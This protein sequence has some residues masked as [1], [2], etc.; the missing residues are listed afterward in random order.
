MT[1]PK[2]KKQSKQ[3]LN[4][5]ICENKKGNKVYVEL[6]SDGFLFRFVRMDGAI[7]TEGE[8]MKLNPKEAPKGFRAVKPAKIPKCTWCCYA[9]LEAGRCRQRSAISCFAD[10]RKDKCNVIFKRIKR[11]GGK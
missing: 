3:K 8:E 11:G 4:G 1:E 7:Q 10:A 2:T 9:D 6:L 5:R